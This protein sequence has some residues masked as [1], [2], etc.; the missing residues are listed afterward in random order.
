M[1]N[2]SQFDPLNRFRENLIK[3]KKLLDQPPAIKSFKFTKLLNDPDFPDGYE[4]HKGKAKATK[5]TGSVSN[6]FQIEVEL[7]VY[8]IRSKTDTFQMIYEE[9]GEDYGSLTKVQWEA[10]DQGHFFKLQKH[11]DI[12]GKYLFKSCGFKSFVAR[13]D[14]LNDDIGVRG[15]E[16]WRWKRTDWRR[17]RRTGKMIRLTRLHVMW[18]HMRWM[19]P[20][21]MFNTDAREEE[22]AWLSPYTLAEMSDEDLIGLD[23]D[24][25]ERR[26]WRFLDCKEVI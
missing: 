15:E 6:P 2:D 26:R 22:I 3:N 17:H 4:L 19:V 14:L 9:L 11:L 10:E 18:L 25:G 5:W 13:A 1:F 23:N 20:Y 16:D 8:R 21:A 7:P 12:I 24:L